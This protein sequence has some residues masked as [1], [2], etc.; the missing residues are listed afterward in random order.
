[1]SR[2]T[3]RAVVEA[4][5]GPGEPG[6]PALLAELERADAA[7]NAIDAAIARRDLNSAYTGLTNRLACL[8][9]EHRLE[10]RAAVENLEQAI[11]LYRRRA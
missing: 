11:A 2:G 5:L 10:T 7:Y 3:D 9:A 6:A 1:M 4:M 8:I